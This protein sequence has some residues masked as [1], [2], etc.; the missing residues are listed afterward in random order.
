MEIDLDR[1]ITRHP[2]GTIEVP[3]LPERG[4]EG[5]DGE[6]VAGGTLALKPGEGGYDDALAAWDLQQDPDRPPAVS[7]AS[8]REQAR[9]VVHAAATTPDSDV[10]SALDVVDDP[11]QA[12]EALRHVLVG[13]NP[14]VED[15][16]AE[17]AE[18]HGGDPLPTHEVTRTIG[19]VLAELEE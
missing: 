18:A 2:D 3:L 10:A 5:D 8:G 9:A 12:A 1:E 11:E 19:T 17:V 7:T 4:A 16:A 14:A 13:G 15:F 6:A